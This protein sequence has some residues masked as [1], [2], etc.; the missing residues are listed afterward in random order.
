[1]NILVAGGSG[2]MGQSLCRVLD[3]RGETVTAVSRTPQ[4]AALPAGVKTVAAD[5]TTRGLTDVVAGHDAVVNLVALPSH[6]QPQSRSHRAVHVAG[7][8]QLVRASE[9][10]EVTRFVQLSGLGVES[11]V[12]TA[13]FRAK[14][15][16]EALVR[17][18]SLESVIYRPSVVFGE[19]C[20]FIPFIE[21]IVPPLIAP[22]PGGGRMRLQ[23]I[24]VEDLGPML[25]DGVTGEQHRG[26]TYE[27]GGPEVLTLAEIVTL[28]RDD[29]RV[30]SV[31]VWL[32][33][34]VAVVADELPGIPIGRD[35]YRVLQLDNTTSENDVRAFGRRPDDL[36]TL[37]DYLAKCR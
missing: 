29:V 4:S 33:A 16:A 8:R 10:T 6:V 23:P 30:V 13:Y 2:F 20:A 14:R 21:R 28:I 26:H 15:R 9:A 12:D 37:D 19:G 5:V 35:Q 22:L 1:M 34:I 7:T 24:W 32:A 11:D 18:S 36:R 3:E 27:I 31:Q 25:A 17:Q